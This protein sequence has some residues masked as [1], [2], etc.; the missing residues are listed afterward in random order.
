[1]GCSTRHGP[2]HEPHT[3]MTVVLPVS[4]RRSWP[5]ATSGPA[6]TGRARSTAVAPPHTGFPPRQATVKSA[7][8]RART[9]AVL[10]VG[11]K[12]TR[13]PLVDYDGPRGMRKLSQA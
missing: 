2:H 9:T 4:T 7:V 6:T 11:D 1:M 8:P 5:S 10:M 13:H 12:A 3:L